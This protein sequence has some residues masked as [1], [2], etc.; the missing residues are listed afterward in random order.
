MIAVV[1][2]RPWHCGQMVRQLRAEDRDGALAC[3]VDVHRELR[4]RL[5]A[6]ALARAVLIDGRLAALG[7]LVGTVL[8]RESCVWLVVAPW[9]IRRNAR[10]LGRLAVVY[11]RRFMQLRHGLYA[12]VFHGDIKAMRLV[13]FLGFKDLGER[14]PYGRSELAVWHLVRE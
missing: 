11:V 10:A 12:T 14:V 3:G 2:A 5:D 9:A 1:D 13:E 7:G 4:H 6:S 8:A